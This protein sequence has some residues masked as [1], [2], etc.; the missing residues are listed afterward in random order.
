VADYY[1]VH[2][3]G[4]GGGA[5]YTNSPIA[6][7]NCSFMHN[8]AFS[9]GAVSGDLRLDTEVG[10]FDISNSEFTNNTAI[11]GDGGAVYFANSVGS[12]T[13]V[14]CASCNL[15]GSY[16]ATTAAGASIT[17]IVA[18]LA[19]STDSIRGQYSALRES[20]WCA[21]TTNHKIRVYSLHIH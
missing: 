2:D 1:L 17:N 5:V 7:V 4:S 9:G 6:I 12:F 19:F 10:S 14:R 3:A 13:K 20:R 15:L 16:Y 18:T 21:C 8:T 11:T